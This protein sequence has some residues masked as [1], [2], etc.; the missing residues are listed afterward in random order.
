MQHKL[1]T[2]FVLTFV[3]ALLV[4]GC[5]APTTTA[6]PAA[7]AAPTQPTAVPPTSV[8]PT[9]VPA[10]EVPATAAPAE[11]NLWTY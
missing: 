3:I 8:P 7:P 5:G 11:V 2:L 10:T 1:R 4:S 9:A 6:T